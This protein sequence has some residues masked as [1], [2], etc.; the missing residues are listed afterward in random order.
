MGIKERRETA[1]EMFARLCSAL[2]EK[3]ID[4]DRDEEEFTVSFK[5]F[6]DDLPMRFT[7]KVNMHR[8]FMMV[9]SRLPFAVH[10]EKY[11]DMALAAC[12]A[13]K[14]IPDGRF[15]FRP[16]LLR[17]DYRMS[18]HYRDS[19]MGDGFFSHLV[20]CALSTVEKYNDKFFSL[21]EGLIALREFMK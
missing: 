1:E 6:G 7:F 2:D 9:S 3:K 10:E 5:I 8:Q 21:N 16:E 20:D 12:I 13:T 14:V 4:Y 19:E 11:T 15:L 17:I 18:W